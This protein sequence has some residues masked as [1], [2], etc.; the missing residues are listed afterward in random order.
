MQIHATSIVI[1]GYGILLMGASG[2]GK[3]DLALRMIDRGARLVSD[4]YTQ[5]ALKDGQLIASPPPRLAG[6]IEVRGLGI[7]TQDY[8]VSAPIVLAITLDPP[9]PRM[10]TH[11]DKLDLLGVSVPHFALSGLESSA[12]LKL[13]RLLQLT[14]MK[15]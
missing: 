4:D 7:L 6:L 10:P 5:L 3:S 9:M 12:P 13:E 1:R 2:S 15:A 8:A 14:L 11:E